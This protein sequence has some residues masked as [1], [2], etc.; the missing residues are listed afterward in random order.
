V[1]KVVSRKEQLNREKKEQ[2][3]AKRRQKQYEISQLT[4]GKDYDKMMEK[5]RREDEK[6]RKMQE[7]KAQYQKFMNSLQKELV[8]KKHSLDRQVEGKTRHA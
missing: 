4:D 8:N 1:G 2:E 7:E 6:Y 3:E 5:M